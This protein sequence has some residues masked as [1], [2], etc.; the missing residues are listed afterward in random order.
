MSRRQRHLKSRAAVWI[1]V[2]A[3]F[4]AIKPAPAQQLSVEAQELVGTWLMMNCGLGAE[5]ALEGRLRTLGE[6]L[7]PPFSR[8]W[9]RVQREPAA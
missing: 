7:E 6:S 4:L 1:V 3:A 2:A 5:P 9:R 8:R